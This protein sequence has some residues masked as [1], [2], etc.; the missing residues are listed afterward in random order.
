[1]QY[2]VASSGLGLTVLDADVS[3]DDPLDV[4]LRLGVPFGTPVMALITE[5][6]AHLRDEMPVLAG[7]SIRRVDITVAEFVVRARGRNRTSV[8]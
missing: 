1:L 7:R 2:A 5:V 8:K 4:A 6:R 3:G